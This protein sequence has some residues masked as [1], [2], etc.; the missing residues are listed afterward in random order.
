MLTLAEMIDPSK[1]MLPP[2]SKSTFDQKCL[3]ET[4]QYVLSERVVCGEPYENSK[5]S[6]IIKTGSSKIRRLESVC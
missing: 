1:S 4:Q 5:N 2:S 6:V 3:S